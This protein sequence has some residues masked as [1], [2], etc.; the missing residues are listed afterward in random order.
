MARPAGGYITALTPCD[1]HMLATLS[2]GRVLLFDL[3]LDQR[4]DYMEPRAVCTLDGSDDNVQR[5]TSALVCTAPGTYAAGTFSGQ[6]VEYAVAGTQLTRRR[7]HVL[8]GSGAAQRKRLEWKRSG[9]DGM[10]PV[11]AIDAVDDGTIVSLGARLGVAAAGAQHWPL[12][13]LPAMGRTW[14]SSVHALDA[15][16]HGRLAV[17]GNG[18]IAVGT[19]GELARN[20]PTATVC[21]PDRYGCVQSSALVAAT[22]LVV[23]TT[24]GNARVV[25]L[26]SARAVRT[27]VCTH[28][29][30]SFVFR[31]LAQPASGGSAVYTCDSTGQVLHWDLR[32]TGRPRALDKLRFGVYAAAFATDYTL[33]YGDKPLNPNK[34]GCIV[35]C[36]TR[37]NVVRCPRHKRLIEDTLYSTSGSGG[38]SSSTGAMPSDALTDDHDAIALPASAGGSAYST[39]TAH[40][41]T[42]PPPGW[43][44]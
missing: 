43:E 44:T 9:T 21:M 24:A 14:V 29:A 16:V 39:S 26:G 2:S 6:L 10:D 35:V 32:D 12:V 5:H 34:Q 33:V 38:A 20:R 23:G 7:V 30:R 13:A 41:A 40:H 4:I 15:S 17:C 11:L 19:L 28:G 3:R 37:M 8:N 25:D 27:L 42:A 18:V 22:T 36:D 31:V 1:G